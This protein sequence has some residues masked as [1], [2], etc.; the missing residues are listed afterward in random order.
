M[1]KDSLSMYVDSHYKYKIKVAIH[2]AE[3][4]Y[5]KCRVSEID[6]SHISECVSEWL[7][8]TAF[9]GTADS[10]VHIVHISH[11]ITAYMLKS[12]GMRQPFCDVTK[13][14]DMTIN[15]LNLVTYLSIRFSQKWCAYTRK[16]HTT[17]NPWHCYVTNQLLHNYVWYI[18][19][20]ICMEPW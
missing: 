7:N 10:E 3:W 9:L 15:C 5:F 2:P 13:S 11:V 17:R 8:L 16:A 12:L 14:S 1:Y 19:I 6:W 4:D 20:L 18:C